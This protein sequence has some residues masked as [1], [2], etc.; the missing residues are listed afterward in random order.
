MDAATRAKTLAGINAAS[1][2]EQ[3]AMHVL[4][5]E[6]YAYVAGGS[7]RDLTVRFNERA[8]DAH[9][10]STR[11]LRDVTLGHTRVRVAGR[12]LAHPILLAPVA[13]QCLFHVDGEIETARGAAASDTCI[14]VSTRSSRRLEEIAQAAGPERWFQLY[15]QPSRDVTLDL[16]GRA[17][18]AGYHVIVVTLDVPIQPASHRALAAGF[19]MPPDV[20]AANLVGYPSPPS[21]SCESGA[22]VLQGL[23]GTAPTWEDLGWLVEQCPVPLWVK[24]VLDPED[25]LRCAQM[26]IAGLIVSNHGG[27]SLDG[28]EAS[29]TA[30][31]RVRA[32]LP[33]PYPLLLDGG[34]R[35]GSDV[36]KALA[37]GADAVLIGRL[38]VYALAV[39]GALGVA[40]MTKLLREELEVCMALTGCA[41]LADIGRE[42]LRPGFEVKGRDRPPP[43]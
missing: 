25:A 28:V 36:F 30:L 24:G 14:V 37:L 4:P 34:I 2:Y 23:M 8:F 40:H 18:G 29:L 1:D 16:V 5:H 10:L 9:A 7:E 22:R 3:L 19:S 35:R 42:A 11:L 26:G 33:K 13:S 43:T 39:A 17:A 12:E 32:A 41:T 21:M 31:P 15:F 27:R 38:Q 20:V 6:T